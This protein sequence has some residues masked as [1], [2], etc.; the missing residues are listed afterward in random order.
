MR[1]KVVRTHAKHLD[2]VGP[3]NLWYEGSVMEVPDNKEWNY[4]IEKGFVV[5]TKEKV[6]IEYNPRERINTSL[7]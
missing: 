3:A 1:I 2:G 4:K 6:N 5:K 7:V